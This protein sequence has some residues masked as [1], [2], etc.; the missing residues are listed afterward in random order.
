MCGCAVRGWDTPAPGDRGLRCATC[1]EWIP[2]ELFEEDGGTTF[3]RIA[4]VQR[5]HDPAGFRSFAVGM[6]LAL[7]EWRRAEAEGRLPARRQPSPEEW[8][9][10]ESL[11]DEVFGPGIPRPD[12]RLSESGPS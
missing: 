6:V 10:A 7:G 2:W 9:Q 11:V 3:N 5:Q 4:G 8:R 1:G 12:G